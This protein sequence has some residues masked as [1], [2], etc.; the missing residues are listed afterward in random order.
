[1]SHQDDTQPKAPAGLREVVEANPQEDTQPTKTILISPDPPT[2]FWGLLMRVGAVISAA[3]LCMAIILLAGAAGVRDELNQIGTQ[4]A[5]AQLAEVAT[6]YALGNIDYQ[7]GRYEMAEIRFAYVETQ[8]PGYQDASVKLEEVQRIMAYTPT[9]SPTAALPTETPEPTTAAPDSVSPPTPEGELDP[10]DL[11]GRAETALNT[12]DFE[13]AIRWLDALVLVDPNYRR[14][15]VQQK[16]LDALI[17]QGR[18][19]L[20]S[21]NPDG[22]DRLAQ[23]VM[24]INRASELGSVPGEL[25]YEADFVARFLAARAY[26]EGGAYDQARPVLI[27]LCEEDCDWNYRGVSVRSLL[28]QVGGG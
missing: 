9:A 10:A 28:A 23:G 12:G 17:A 8:M 1:M 5:V 27:R 16:R 7:S 4:A 6:Q 18:I 24:L 11:Y 13:E 26:V 22:E 14:A 19:Y 21:Q 3:F 2:N 15:E 25:L 20:R